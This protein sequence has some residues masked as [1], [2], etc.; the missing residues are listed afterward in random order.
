[1]T[2]DVIHLRDFYASPLG[3]IVKS[4]IKQL[5][6]KVWSC[7]RDEI[8]V[9]L[10][11][12]TPF[13][14]AFNTEKNSLL[15]FMP[16]QQGVLGWPA[17]RPGL[18]S[19]VEEDMLPLKDK[20]ADK[21]VLIHCLENCHNSHHVLR[22]AWRVLK[23]DGKL[24]IIVPNR[25]GLWASFDN[26]PFGHGQPYTMTQ[27]S[28]L[29]KASLFTPLSSS[30]GLYTPPSTSKFV[31][32]ISPLVEKIGQTCLQKFSGIV[33]IEATKEVY[34]GIPIPIRKRFVLPA[35]PSSVEQGA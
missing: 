26:T 4:D 23:P 17:K 32:A 34:A 16:A 13:L 30:R 25:R 7:R 28:N 9:G 10:G 22:E 18:S 35:M 1:M 6:E 2:I 14:D 11:Y 5:I 27:L 12:T 8:I 24:L 3:H 19:L 15:A 31:Q 33:C 21:L 20:T 29:L